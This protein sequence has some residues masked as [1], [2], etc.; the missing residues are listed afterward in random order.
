MFPTVN[1]DGYW[2]R[3]NVWVVMTQNENGT[4]WLSL[5]ETKMEAV[6]A[7][8]NWLHDAPADCKPDAVWIVKSPH[9][10]GCE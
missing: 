2:S 6:T 9:F 5:H 7:A 3:D 10:I 1:V 8:Q 4:S